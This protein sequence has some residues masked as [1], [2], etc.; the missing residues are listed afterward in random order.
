M[1]DTSPVNASASLSKEQVLHAVATHLRINLQEARSGFGLF[2]RHSQPTVLVVKILNIGDIRSNHNPVY[3]CPHAMVSIEGAISPDRHKP[4]IRYIVMPWLRIWQSV[5]WVYCNA[6][7]GYIVI[8]GSN[9]H[10]P[11][12]H[13]DVALFDRLDLLFVSLLV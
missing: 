2:G 4:T 12:K 7:I 10:C 6:S 1:C 11:V 8:W 3:L 5:G 9:T 13:L